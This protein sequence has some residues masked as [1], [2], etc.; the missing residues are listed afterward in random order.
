[1]AVFPAPCG[2]R[3][4]V[5]PVRPTELP[6]RRPKHELLLLA[7]VALASLTI[8]YPVGAQDVSRMCLT[9]AAAHGH[10]S[11]DECLAGGVDVAHFGSHLYS[12]KAPG[13][14]FLALP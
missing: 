11:A 5:A 1:M 12:D 14:S 2:L 8:V 6:W 7:L 3:A 10:L 13:V 4:R 9:R